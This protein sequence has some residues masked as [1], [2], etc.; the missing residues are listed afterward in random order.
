MGIFFN[1]GDRVDNYEYLVINERDARASAGI[2]FLLG[3]LSLF[4]VYIFRTLLWAEL[5]SITFIFEFF[6]RIVF[7]P[8]YAPYMLLGG[9]IV[10]NQSPDWVEAKPKQFAW[11]LGLIL[12]A[13]MAYYII[14]D[15]ISLWRIALC[16][17]C[18]I[19][20]FLESTFG[21]CLGCLV[22]NALHIKLHH[23]PGDVCEIPRQKVLVKHRAW[24]LL[25]FLLLF[26]FTY[27]GLQ[28]SK[29]DDIPNVIILDDR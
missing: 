15:I 21:I 4:S 28:S 8:K 18:L 27:L 9:F 22:Y 5:F 10:S 23:C 2:M 7:A 24:F 13:I 16:V 12:G 3:M 6:V 17:V 11:I 14:Y 25:G 20:L 19:L 29:Y 26:T 1:F